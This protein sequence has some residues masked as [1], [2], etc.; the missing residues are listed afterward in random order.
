MFRR[1]AGYA[2]GFVL[3]EGSLPIV[4]PSYRASMTA[5]LLGKRHTDCCGKSRGLDVM[6]VIYRNWL[7]KPEALYFRRQLGPF[8]PFGWYSPPAIGRKS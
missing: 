2:L 8:D 3:V 7:G 4:L 1:D 6:P 5:T